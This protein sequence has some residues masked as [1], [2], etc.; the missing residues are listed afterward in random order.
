MTDK[1]YRI[2]RMT[3]LAAIGEDMTFA[4]MQQL[5]AVAREFHP[6]GV[7]GLNC[8]TGWLIDEL[9]GTDTM[10]CGGLGGSNTGFEPT[11][12]KVAEAREYVQMGC[13]DVD[14]IMNLVYLRSGMYDEALADLKAV[15]A[16]VPNIMKVIIE[17]PYLKDEKLIKTACDI[18]IESGAD[19]VKTSTGVFGPTTVE[20]VKL[21]KE[22]VGERIKVKAAG[23]IASVAM[24][25]ELIAVGVDRIGLGSAK[26]AR[27]CRENG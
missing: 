18:V 9:R 2:A 13:G 3:D 24:I 14:L 16:A 1:M 8:F 5:V 11:F 25:D 7:F 23:G 27:F 15:R 20:Q 22:H 19:F 17:T 21:V 10:A 4:D 26:F 12:L 6:Y